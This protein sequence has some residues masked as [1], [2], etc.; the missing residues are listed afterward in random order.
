MHFFFAAA[1]FVPGA[2]SRPLNLDGAN[3]PAP[4]SVFTILQHLAPLREGLSR[5]FHTFHFRAI[6]RVFGERLLFAGLTVGG[7]RESCRG[8]PEPAMA[9]GAHSPTAR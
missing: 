6:C 8:G 9:G 7:T 3:W 4:P 1:M 5:K 2:P